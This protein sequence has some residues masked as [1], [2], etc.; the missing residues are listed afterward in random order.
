M[1]LAFDTYYEETSAK[2]VC[3]AFENW[4]A[5]NEQQVY[6]ETLKIS[7]AYESGQFYKRELPC[8]L[9][10][11]KQINQTAVEA[12]IVDGFVV[13]DDENKPGL[14]MYLYDILNKKIPVIGVAKTNFATLV[15]NKYSLL[16]GDSIKPLYITSAGINLNDAAQKIKEMAGPY[17]IPVLL[18]KLDGLTKMNV[19]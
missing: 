12:I 15:H 13:L 9:S 14:G 11:L 19:H 17:R 1:I 7:A 3:I 4:S 10:L 5:E 18:K 8:I 16:R 2:T 6:T